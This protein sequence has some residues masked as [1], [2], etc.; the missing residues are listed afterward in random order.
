[1]YHVRDV[2]KVSGY[3]VSSAYLCVSERMQKILT[4]EIYP[5]KYITFRTFRSA[6]ILFF[7]LSKNYF[8]KTPDKHGT[9]RN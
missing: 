5:Y 2:A 1:M 7:G 8:A 4:N 3:V 6:Q 9:T